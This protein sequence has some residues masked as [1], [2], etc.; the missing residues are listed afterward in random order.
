MIDN[1]NI[2]IAELIEIIPGPDFPTGG[3]FMAGRGILDA[4]MHGMG[5]VMVRQ[6][7]RRRR[8]RW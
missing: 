5:Q 7:A 3:D 1:P 6:G 2:S 8:S 4:Y